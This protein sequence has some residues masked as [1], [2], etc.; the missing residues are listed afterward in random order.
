MERLPTELA[1]QILS[2]MSKEELKVIGF[3]S[4]E[5]RS[6]VIPFLFRRIRPWSLGTAWES[7]SDITTYLQNSPHLSSAVRVLD[8][9]LIRNFQ[10]RNPGEDLQ[11]IME[12]TTLWEELILPAGNRLP[13]AVFSENTKSQLRRLRCIGGTV[14]L[15][16][17]RLLD[18]LPTCTS[19][20]VLQIPDIEEDWFESVDPAG[21]VAAKWV[22]RLEKYSGPLYPLKYLHSGTPLYHLET[23][24]EVPLSMLQRLGRLLGQRLLA[25]H[26]HLYVRFYN[27]FNWTRENHLQ[28][29][30]IPSV[31]PNLR[32]VAWFLIKSEPGSIPNDIVRTF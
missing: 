31:F 28:P 27:H 25:L 9:E 1:I 11:R 19:L 22:N 24:T 5:Y 16:F 21:L 26:V 29:S 23:T 6:L 12:I 7:I 2:Y 3:I 15:E 30:P 14:G 8:V 32:F 10:N 4:S 17:H 20:V 13:L 18:I